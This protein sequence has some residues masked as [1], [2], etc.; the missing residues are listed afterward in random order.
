MASRFAGAVVVILACAAVVLPG[1]ALA[2]G[3]AHVP[4]ALV[5]RVPLA[6]GVPV[7]ALGAGAVVAGVTLVGIAVRTLTSLPSH[8]GHGPKEH[9]DSQ[10]GASDL[11][12][13]P[14]PPSL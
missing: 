7:V 6:S 9:A 14:P 11:L 1:V 10:Q 8:A 4:T 12:H 13:C 3:P 5:V 2:V